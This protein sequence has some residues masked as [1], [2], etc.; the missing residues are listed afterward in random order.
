MVKYFSAIKYYSFL[1]PFCLELCSEDSCVV[2]IESRPEP[3]CSS[4]VVSCIK[5]FPLSFLSYI[6][7]VF[8]TVEGRNAAISRM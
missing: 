8:A 6:L 5:S 3:R 1:L 2:M 4:A 7:P